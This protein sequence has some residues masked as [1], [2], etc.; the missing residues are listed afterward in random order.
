MN[1]TEFVDKTY[2]P[3]HLRALAR[4]DNGLN[5]PMV[6]TEQALAPYLPSQIF[7]RFESEIWAMLMRSANLSSETPWQ[8]LARWQCL[9]GDLMELKYWLALWAISRLAIDT[10]RRALCKE[11]LTTEVTP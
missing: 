5:L 10:D 3:E 7:D 4:C 8:C 1:L 11:T 6:E 2:S 9:A